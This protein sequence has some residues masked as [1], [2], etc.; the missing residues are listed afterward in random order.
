M[1]AVITEADYRKQIGKTAGHAYLFFGDEDYM[2]NYAVEL[3]RENISPDAAFAVFNDITIDA[4]DFTID[5]LLNAMAP[6]P[7]MADGRLILIRGL[8][9]NAMKRDDM[10]PLYDAL[11]EA[12]AL[13]PEYDYNTVIIQVAADLIDAGNAKKPS[14][15]LKQLSEVVVPVRFDPVTPSRLCAWAIKHFAHHGVTAS[16]ELCQHLIAVSGRDMFR[17]SGEIKKI[18][19][20]VL[21]HERTTLQKE[22]VDAL[23]VP[24]I[25]MDTYALSNALLTRDYRAALDVLAVLKFERAK[26]HYVLGS[27]A[28][29]LTEVYATRVAMDEGRTLAEIT[30]L[31]FK[32]GKN[33]EYKAKLAMRSA[34]STSVA[35]IARVIELCAEADAKVKR[36]STDGFEVLERLICSL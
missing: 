11:L 19:H 31:F 36:S 30:A 4:V 33:G 6:P 22:D 12:L 9:F 29:T 20:Y 32:N 26:P 34:S 28:A 24:E 2:K 7:M 35:Q 27:I 25:S 23:A 16:P 10:K 8:D 5:G 14:Q 17:L 21:A 18:A 1:N 13:L 3:T 15:M